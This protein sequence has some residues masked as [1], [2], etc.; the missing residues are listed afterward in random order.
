MILGRGLTRPRITP[1]GCAATTRKLSSVV[2]VV[3]KRERRRDMG[4]KTCPLGMI[5]TSCLGKMLDKA[6]NQGKPR[7]YLRNINVRWFG[8]DLSDV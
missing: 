7:K 8:F 6:K 5:M 3:F 1:R 4:V 2:M